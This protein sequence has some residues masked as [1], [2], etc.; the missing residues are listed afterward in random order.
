MKVSAYISKIL[1]VIF[2]LAGVKSYAQKTE[3]GGVLG[4]SY[5]WG[6]VVNTFQPSTANIGGTFFMRYHLNS[7]VALRGNLSYAKL[8]GSDADSKDSEW[9]RNRNFSFTTEIIELSG[10]AE[11]NLIPDKNKGRRVKTVFVP[12]VFGGVGLFYFN[13]KAINPVTGQELALRPLKLDGKGY[14]P[15][16]I[17]IPL[18]I[19][20]RTYLTRNW[21]IGVELGA[22]YSLS[23]HIDDVAGRSEYPSVND[24]PNEQ[25]RIMF[26]PS[27]A[28]I[29]QIKESGDTY[30]PG[31]NSSPGDP[32]GKNELISDVYFIGGVT[33]S[34][35][36]WPRGAARSYGGRAIRCPRFY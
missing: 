23:S 11:Y 19:G 32:R 5:Y 4:V 33:L 1:L 31:K 21:Q 3:I 6:D 29:E 7:R 22:R 24:L 12:Y 15:V 16:A 36:I 30:V 9:Q 10:V 2:A 34:Y 14:S 25:A 13:P 28:R 18:G 8:G 35:R 27:K 26:D 17:C 20:F